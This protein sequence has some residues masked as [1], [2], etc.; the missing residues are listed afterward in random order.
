MYPRQLDVVADAAFVAR[1]LDVESLFRKCGEKSE[2]AKH[3]L[4][5]GNK[6]AGRG[7]L[8]QG[9]VLPISPLHCTS[10][11]ARRKYAVNFGPLEHTA[12]FIKRIRR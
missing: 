7:R 1:T 10:E 9:P 5:F 4:I 2:T 12:L 11:I 8:K 6:T 3:N